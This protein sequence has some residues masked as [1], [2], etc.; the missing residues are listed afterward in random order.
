MRGV[1][2]SWGAEYG[3]VRGPDDVERF[4]HYSDIEADGYRDLAPGTLVEFEPGEDE[5]GPL[6]ERVRLIGYS[7]SGAGPG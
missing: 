1:C 3:F 2:V 4:V 5:R 7:T 6:A